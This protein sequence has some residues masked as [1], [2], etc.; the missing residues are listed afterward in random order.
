LSLQGSGE[1]LFNVE[2]GQSEQYNQQY[3]MKIQAAIPMGI[4]VQP[5]VTVK[6]S[7]TANLL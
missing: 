6:Q 4:S 7:I 1:E 5:L 3:E 2:T